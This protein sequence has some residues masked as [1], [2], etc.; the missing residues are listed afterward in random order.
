MVWKILWKN[1]RFKLCRIHLL[2]ALKPY[3]FC[4]EKDVLWE[5]ARSL[6]GRRLSNKLVLSDEATFLLIGKID[7]HNVRIWGKESPHENLEQEHDFVKINVFTQFLIIKCIDLSFLGRTT[8]HVFPTW[9]IMVVSAT[10]TRYQRFHLPTGCSSATL[11]QRVPWLSYSAT[12][13]PIDWKLQQRW[14]DTDYM[15]IQIALPFTMWIL[16]LR[17]C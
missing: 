14:Q 9:T 15:K 6:W 2:Q 7:R 13:T 17:I 12:P 3:V 11:A 16:R 8:W 5:H 1:L 4:Q 10:W